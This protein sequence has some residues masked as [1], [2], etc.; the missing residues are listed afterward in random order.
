MPT[1][2]YKCPICNFI[3]KESRSITESQFFTKC[4]STQCGSSDFEE[5]SVE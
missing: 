5:I 3:Y 4:T 2:T 1:Y